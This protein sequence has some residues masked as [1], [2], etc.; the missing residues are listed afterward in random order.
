MCCSL[1]LK[2]RIFFSVHA[3]KVPVAGGSILLHV[4]YKMSIRISHK[5]GFLIL[6]VTIV[7]NRTVSGGG[8]RISSNN[9][10]MGSHEVACKKTTSSHTYV[11]IS[12]HVAKTVKSN[13]TR[14]CSLGK[15]PVM[16]TFVRRLK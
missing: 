2:P 7:L 4:I 8:Y 1:G 3:R 5:L 6:R 16:I 13:R 10:C 12:V 14:S 15:N 9:T 11:S